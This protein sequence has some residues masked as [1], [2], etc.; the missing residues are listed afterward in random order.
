MIPHSY[1]N[2]GSVNTKK[3]A[4]AGW[5]GHSSLCFFMLSVSVSIHHVLFFFFFSFCSSF[6]LQRCEQVISG[7][8]I[9]D[10]ILHRANDIV[11][12]PFSEEIKALSKCHIY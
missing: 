2:G 9:N 4:L 7:T 11:S 6:H 8:N 5:L 1:H 10:H 3:P 12:F